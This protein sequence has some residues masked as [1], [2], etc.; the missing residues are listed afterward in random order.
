MAATERAAESKTSG[1][2]REFLTFC[3][4]EKGLSRNSLDAYSHDLSDFRSY[5]DPLTGGDF[6][7]RR[8]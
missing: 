2:I 7:A 1:A 8:S 4:M 5:T 3:R 6:P